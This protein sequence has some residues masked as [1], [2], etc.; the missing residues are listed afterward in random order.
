L[1]LPVET[2]VLASA[3]PSTLRPRSHWLPEIEE[4]SVEVDFFISV[5]I[6]NAH[7]FDVRL[8]FLVQ[9]VCSFFFGRVGSPD[10]LKSCSGSGV[11]L[12]KN[13]A[14]VVDVS[15]VGDDSWLGCDVE[16]SGRLKAIVM[17][18]VKVAPKC[19]K[20]LQNAD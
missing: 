16:H 14:W 19:C 17:H 1:L 20:K 11:A 2:R 6:E 18:H 3:V 5:P 8:L 10:R 15:M 12:K 4:P 13:V 9:E 7:F